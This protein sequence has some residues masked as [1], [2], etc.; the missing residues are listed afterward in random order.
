[1]EPVI[2]YGI[3]FCMH[4]LCSINTEKWTPSFIFDYLANHLISQAININIQNL[5]WRYQILQSINTY[6]RTLIYKIL[7]TNSMIVFTISSISVYIYILLYF[8]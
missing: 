5:E 6:R 3:K 8:G 2:Q 7:I 4:N 1:M